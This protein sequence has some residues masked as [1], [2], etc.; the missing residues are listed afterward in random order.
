MLLKRINEME[1]ETDRVPFTIHINPS[2]HTG[3]QHSAEY[4]DPATRVQISKQLV[5]DFEPDACNDGMPNPGPALE[6]LDMKSS[7]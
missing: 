7:L 1:K 6:T 2:N 4:Y 5:V 3:I